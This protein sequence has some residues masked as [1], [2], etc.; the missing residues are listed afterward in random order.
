[1]ERRFGSTRLAPAG[2]VV[3]HAEIEKDCVLLDVRAAAGSATCPCCGTASSRHQSRYVRQAADLPI[4]G[5]GLFCGWRFADSGATP[6]F[7]AV[8]FLQNDLAPI[9][10]LPCRA[11]P[12]A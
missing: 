1:M 6:F 3:E 2:F 9:H 8:A 7:A 10:W 11:G 12:D 5:V 4:S